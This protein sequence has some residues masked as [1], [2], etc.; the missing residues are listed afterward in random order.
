MFYGD[1]GNKIQY[2]ASEWDIM[3]VYVPLPSIHKSPR[4]HQAMEPLRKTSC[5][6]FCR[7]E[8]KITYYCDIFSLVM[9]ISPW[10]KILGEVLV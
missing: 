10:L 7:Y 5:R 2:C 9:D 4:H 8:E 3:S 1:F 6:R